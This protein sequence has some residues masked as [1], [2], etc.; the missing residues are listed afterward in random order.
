[1]RLLEPLTVPKSMSPPLLLAKRVLFS[2]AV[3]PLA[4]PPPP[5]TAEF[6]EIVTLVST[7]VAWLPIP[8]P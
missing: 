1:M 8:P 6:P 2:V 7:T 5:L 4:M 3:P